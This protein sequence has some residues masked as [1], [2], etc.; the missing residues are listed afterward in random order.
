MNEEFVFDY[1]LNANEE[2]MKRGIKEFY[3]FYYSNSVEEKDSLDLSYEDRKVVDYLVSTIDLDNDVIVKTYGRE[4]Q[5]LI[6]GIENT[7]SSNL[8]IQEQEMLDNILSAVKAY[9]TDC[10]SLNSKKRNFLRPTINIEGI[11]KK[12][13]NVEEELDNTLIRLKRERKRTYRNFSSMKE[14][15]I[16]IL[17][18]DRSLQLYII[19]GNEVLKNEH[20]I[21]KDANELLSTDISEK[22]YKLLERIKLFRERVNHLEIQK[23]LLVNQIAQLKIIL[24]NSILVYVKID[25]IIENVIPKWRLHMALLL[26]IQV[27]NGT[28]VNDDTI[29]ELKQLLANYQEGK[30]KKNNNDDELINA[31][32]TASR[33][34]SG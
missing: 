11:K 4:I 15:L 22:D 19:A 16:Q 9:I 8:L 13:L 32:I 20:E 21:C 27:V 30:N 7:I 12:Y 23:Y 1:D 3:D 6:E 2:I 24:K 26:N 14:V 33:I 28:L 17:D 29:E 5:C 18:I 25:D 10:E 31:L 34:M